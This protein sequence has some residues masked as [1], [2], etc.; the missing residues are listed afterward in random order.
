MMFMAQ[1][2]VTVRVDDIDGRDLGDGGETVQFS[3]DNKNYEIDL[4]DSNAKKL[5]SVLDKY[6]IAARR[7]ASGTSVRRSHV[8]GGSGMSKEELA[9]VR[10]WAKDNGHQISERGRI[11][12]A[13][14]EA[15]HKAM[16]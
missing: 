15:Y 3:L 1:R 5:R 12:A 16:G 10:T 8:S 6:I 14:M 11:K 7:S 9:N 13:I 2:V 4:S